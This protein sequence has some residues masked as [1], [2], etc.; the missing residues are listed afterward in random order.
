MADDGMAIDQLIINDRRERDENAD[1]SEISLQ[2]DNVLLF[3][4]HKHNAR[5]ICPILKALMFRDHCSITVCQEGVR[6]VV[7]DQ[8][9]QS[10][11]AYFKDDHFSEFILNLPPSVNL[12]IPLGALTETLN[13]F[14]GN[15]VVMRMSY[16]GQGEPLS[17]IVEEGGTVFGSKINTKIQQPVLDFEFNKAKILCKIIL[18]PSS[19]RDIIRDFDQSSPNVLITTTKN[20]ISFY[21]NGDLGRIKTQ[22][23]ADADSIELLEC[24]GDKVAYQYKIIHV[25]RMFNCFSLCN[26]VSMRIDQRGVLNTQFLV[27]QS[28]QQTVFIEF[29]IVA[30]SDN[31]YDLS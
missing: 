29:F 19:I 13:V 24:Q 22:I 10:G 1:V 21:T 12:R 16:G 15:T 8:H 4:I 11:S 18:M 27:P 23:N 25:R 30:D 3:E 14:T 17:V 26:K 2:R 28:E 31:Y 7:D 9:N 6:I 20:C 5:E